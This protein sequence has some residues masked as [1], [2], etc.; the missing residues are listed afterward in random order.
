MWKGGRAFPHHGYDFENGDN[1]PIDSEGHGTATAGQVAGNGASGTRT[2]VAPEAQIMAI[3]VGGRER[4][5]WNAMQF[6]LDHGANVISMSMSWKFPSSPDYPAWRRACESILAAGVLHA[7]SIGNQGDDLVNYPIPFNIATPGSCPP[8][9][10][11]PLQSTRGGLSSSIAC[12]ATDDL[13]RLAYYSGRGPAAWEAGP[14]VDYPYAGGTEFGLIKP[15]LC[16]PGPGTTSCNFQ[17]PSSD[18][19]V[20]PYVSFSGTS[21]ATPHVG[22]CLALLAQACKL[23]GQP[24]VP[25][26]IQEALENTAVRIA[27]QSLDKEIHYGAGRVDVYAAYQYGQ[28]KGWW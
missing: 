28:S 8:P 26:R 18:R 7:N 15:D 17:F 24:V 10:L 3:R 5:F 22:G 27:G 19:T 1:D 16:A 4:S 2:G 20:R 12:G 11:H 9:W 25:G 13:D 14:F 23:A 21:A 6:A